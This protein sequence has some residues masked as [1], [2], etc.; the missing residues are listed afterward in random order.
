MTMAAVTKTPQLVTASVDGVRLN[1]PLSLDKNVVIR[2]V[3]S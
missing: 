3:A 1:R 2:E